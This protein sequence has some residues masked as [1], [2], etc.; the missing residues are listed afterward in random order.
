METKVCTKC[1]KEKPATREFFHKQKDG[2]HGFRPDCKVCVRSRTRRWR[3]ENK[4][5]IAEKKKRYREEN[6][7]KIAEYNKQYYE[8]NREKLAEYYE[9]NREKFAEKN[10]MYYEKNRERERLRSRLYARENKEA[11]GAYAK[12]RIQNLP[13]AVYKITNRVNDTTY[14]GASTAYKRRWIN[15]KNQLRR[16]V[17]VNVGL[18]EDYSKYGLDVFEF[19]VL[20]EHPCDTDFKILEKIEQETI[21]RFLAEGK[22]LYNIALRVNHG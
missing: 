20:E 16:G 22:K 7:E 13:A 14:I 3:V 2:R 9:K 18:Q 1:E 4:E 19:E 5:K 10:R 12:R 17:H 21:K 6:K 8:E 15:H 11:R